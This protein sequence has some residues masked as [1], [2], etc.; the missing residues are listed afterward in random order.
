MGVKVID[1]SK[2]PS[3]KQYNPS[4][5]EDKCGTLMIIRGDKNII[6]ETTNAIY[7]DAYYHLVAHP[8]SFILQYV[9]KFQFVCKVMIIAYVDDA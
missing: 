4:V 6:Q 3:S 8:G 7:L 2:K 9:V 1:F 5:I